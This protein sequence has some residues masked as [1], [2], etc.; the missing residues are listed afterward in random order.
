MAWKK[1]ADD[2]AYR[3]LKRDIAAGSIGNLYIFHG[4]EVYL[5]DYYLGKMK[6]TLLTGGLDDFNFHILQGKDCTVRKIQE[7]VDAMPMMSERT[8]VVV[9]DYDIYKGDGEAMTALISDLPDYVCLVFLYDVIPYKADNRMK[10]AKLVKEKG[11]IVDFA[12]Q[13]Q[14]DLTDWI[15]RRFRALGHDISTGDAQYLIFLCGDLMTGLISEIGKIGAYAKEKRVTRQDIDA[16]ATPQLDAVVFQLTDAIAAGNFDRAFSVLGDLL[17]MQEA[18]IKL[19]AVLGRQIRQLYTARLAI[20]GGK[21]SK[22]LMELWGM[23]MSYQA[24]KLMQSARKFSLDWCRR[25][26]I[27]CEETDLAMKST[28]ADGGE[29]LTGLLLELSVKKAS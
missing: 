17:H 16:V 24:E 27:R 7:M 4:E 11:Q 28:G 19:L 13:D 6:E 12:R 26:V 9:S 25:A 15:A 29:L 14:G 21:G 2:S 10:L 18:P 22:W 5:R 23:R 8:L 3:T 1:K 20:E